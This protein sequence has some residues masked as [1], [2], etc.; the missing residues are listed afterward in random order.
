MLLWKAV[1]ANK[2]LARVDL[3]LFLNKCDILAAK[4]AAGVR[5]A[6]YVRNFGERANERDVVE[7]CAFC[8]LLF[9]FFFFS[10]IKPFILLR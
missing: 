1:C 3:V 4:L 6:K 5:L 8:V 10:R 2:L 9:F 7:K